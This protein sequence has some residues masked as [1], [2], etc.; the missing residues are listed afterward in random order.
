[1]APESPS[2]SAELIRAVELLCEAFDRKSTSYAIIGGLA[3]LMRGRPRFTQDV[4]VLIDVRQLALPDL[5]ET[6]AQS[7]FTFDMTTAMREYTREHMTVLR[8]GMVRVDWLKPIL[9]LYARALADA[10]T[11]I[12]S[13]GHP[14]RVATAEGVILTK[15]VAFRPQDQVD[16]EVLLSANRD[17]IDL[18]CIRREWSAVSRGEEA[19]TAWL[20]GAIAR[21]VQTPG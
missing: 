14:V 10:S 19:R 12:W 4:D 11:L 3:T 8:F 9:P 1:M 2:L 5:L 13:E 17:Q 7:G 6:L 18:D 20:E 21:L 16:I 15:L